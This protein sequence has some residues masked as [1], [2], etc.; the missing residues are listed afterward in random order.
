MTRDER[1]S[2]LHGRRMGHPL[3]ARQAELVET[4]L[5]DLRLDL[6]ASPVPA[7][8]F[9]RPVTAFEMEI[10]FGG[11]EHLAGRA[12]L[13]PQTGFIGCEPFLNGV[14]KLL[15][16]IEERELG[17]IRIH[18][19]DARQVL[20]RLPDGCLD[21]VWLLYPDPWP[22]RRH[23]KRR[24]VADDNLDILARVLKPGGELLFASDWADYVDWTLR[25]L[26]RRPDFQ[27]TARRADDWRLPWPGWPGTRYEAKAIREGRT[28]CYLTFRRV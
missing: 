15:V 20:D 7:E 10:G 26:A 12:S 16:E 13:H 17:N 27:W 18:D 8:L 3:R 9:P 24:F 2:L 21:R 22:K 1:R 28:P 6:D 11:G 4:R 19:G 25:C 23:W 14:A 5:P